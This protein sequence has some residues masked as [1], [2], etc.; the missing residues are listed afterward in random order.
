[1]TAQEILNLTSTKTKKIQML[2]GIGLTRTEVARLMGI[3]YGFVQNVYAKMNSTIQPQAFQFEFIFNR[4]FG[5]EIEAYGCDRNALAE[6]LQSKGIATNMASRLT[7]SNV[8]KITGDGSITGDNSFEIVSPILNGT[9]GLEQ[10]KKVCEALGELRAKINKTCGMHIHFSASDFNVATW[11]NLY[12]N[13]ITFETTIDK[14]MPI[15]RRGNNNTYCK[16]LLTDNKERVFQ[17]ID[18]ARTLQQISQAV[19]GRNRYY[20][21]NAEAF[22]RHNTVEF[23]QH[24]GTIEFEK[25]QNWIL[26][27]ARMVEYSTTRVATNETIESAEFLTDEIKAFYETRTRQLAI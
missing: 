5:V 25:I 18:T 17:K 10:L 23:R 13:Y 16:S 22:F 12:K 26:F 19:T 1:M 9:N 20:K 11:K 8:W 15:S 14:F 24:S 7:Q 2:L 3:G 27:L 4:N 6:L 21:I